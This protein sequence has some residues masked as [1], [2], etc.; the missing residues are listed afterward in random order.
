MKT[1]TP[2]SLRLSTEEKRRLQAAAKKRGLSLRRFLVDSALKEAGR[3][4]FTAIFAAL[5]AMPK[6]ETSRNYS[7][8]EGFGD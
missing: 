5:P 4:D 1:A 8:K 3:V 2:T 6:G 7:T